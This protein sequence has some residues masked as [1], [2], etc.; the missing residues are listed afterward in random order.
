MD[1]ML[2]CITENLILKRF[3]HSSEMLVLFT[4]SLLLQVFLRTDTSE[5]EKNPR[6]CEFAMQI[7]QAYST[8]V[9][10]PIS[11]NKKCVLASF[12]KRD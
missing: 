3:I 7:Y 4:L 2:T 11:T 10:S 9:S 1:C 12:E 6:S 8:A 5:N